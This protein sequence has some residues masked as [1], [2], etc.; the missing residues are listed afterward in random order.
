M[1]RMKS[2]FA[3]LLL[4]VIVGVAPHA[5]AQTAK[6]VL[7]GSSWEWQT[8]ALAAWNNGTCPSPH[9]NCKH[10]TYAGVH[11]NDTRN[12]SIPTGETGNLW[13]V[14]DDSTNNYWAYLTVDSI[15]GDRCY[16]AHPRCNIGN[17]S[18]GLGAIQNKIATSIWGADTDL[19]TENPTVYAQFTAS[20]GVVVNAA[21]TDIRPE[22]ALFGQCRV[23]SKLGG[24]A[25]GLAGLGWGNGT[26]GACPKF[27][28]PLANKIGTQIKSGYPGSTS[29]AN[30]VAFNIS[31]KDPFTN[32]PIPAAHTVPVGAG[33]LVFITNRQGALAGVTNAT[34]SQLQA[35]YSGANCKGSAFVGGGTGNI[36]VYNREPLSGTMNTAEADVFR[37]PDA[38]GKS[39]ETGL[40]VANPL[41]NF[42]CSSGGA[43]WR[44]IGTGEEVKFVLNSNGNF[45]MDG[46]GYT[47][48]T[49]GNVSSIANSANY[50]YLQLNG[51]D[52]IF[53]KYGTTIDPAQPAIPG[54]LPS[55]ATLPAV[56]AGQFPC[57]EKQMW[58]GNLSFPNLRNGSYRGWTILRLVSDGVALANVKL[59]VIASQSVAA[60]ITPDYVPFV[61][62]AAT[63]PGF[64]LLRSHYTQEGV[65]P[66]NTSPIGDKGGDMGGCILT[67]TALVATSDTTTKLAQGAEG[68]SCVVVP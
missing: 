17:G 55:T 61:K 62:V 1:S 57:T 31:G 28:D 51:I 21:A 54:A 22:D 66:I 34:E 33:A 36:A 64:P 11:L 38:S 14:W 45:G 48:F 18:A 9:G 65:A 60:E 50:G 7:S 32:Q 43:R 35:V 2:I 4:T 19:A 20:A 56:C 27:T 39:Q 12:S 16:F 23:N 30:V 26:S 29:L 15:V 10:A 68:S 58:S 5:G 6:V 59:L 24:G 67:A 42:P 8:I 53:H 41:A 37:R 25:D 44:S 52:P 13:V 46:I 3:L 40:G 47:G 49:F 63:D